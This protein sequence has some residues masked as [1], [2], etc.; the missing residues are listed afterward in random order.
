MMRVLVDAHQLGR[1][2]T[3]NETYVR[4]LLRGLRGCDDLE[5]AGSP[6]EITARTPLG[7]LGTAEE[8]ANAVAFPASDEA[9][10]ITGQVLAVDGGLVMT[11][12]SALCSAGR[13]CLGSQVGRGST[14][15]LR[16]VAPELAV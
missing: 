2:Q 12:R 16:G 10:Y 8:I 5:L 15:V 9:T 11:Q 13:P 4:E 14:R 1:R 6:D 3:G 7:G